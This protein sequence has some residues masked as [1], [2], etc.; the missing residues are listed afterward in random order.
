MPQDPKQRPPGKRVRVLIVDDSAL[1]RRLLTDMLSSDCSIEV[2]GAVGDAYAA[3]EKIKALN[4]DV[5]TLDVEMPKMDGYTFLRNLMRLRPMPVIVVS[6]LTEHGAS[7]TLDAL[8]AGAVDYLPKPKID[9]APTLALYRDEL[10][11][12]VHAAAAARVRPVATCMPPATEH[13]EPG[14]AQPTFPRPHFRSTERIVAVGASTGGTEA[15]KELLM[16]LPSDM[17][18]VLIAQHIPKAFSTQFAKRMNA[19]SRMS[20]CEAEDGQQI[21]PG[22]AYIAP[23]DRHLLLERDGS[24]YICRLD[25]GEP[26][27][28][29]RPAVDALFHSVAQQAGANAV[30]VI[31][32]GMGKDGALGL[33]EMRRA[34]APTIVQDEATSVVWGMPGE[35]VAI[36][37]ALHVLPLCSIGA[38][39]YRLAASDAAALKPATGVP[40]TR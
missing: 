16:T 20:V 2:L 40:L 24:R 4:P 32:T 13:F 14:S 29:H 1:V 3:R 35:A 11:L 19:C 28:R 37:A 25:D 26:V 18:G 39:I 23:G 12:K 21:L 31:L 15:V 7:I 38:A 33:L 27:N 6:S 30:G 34:G 17:P 8:A 36:G 5:L 10:I 9:I 22:H